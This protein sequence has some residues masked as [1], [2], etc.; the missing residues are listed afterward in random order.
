MAVPEVAGA[1]L[2]LIEFSSRRCQVDANLAVLVGEYRADTG[3][4]PSRAVARWQD[5]PTL[6]W[7][8][9][10]GGCHLNRPIDQLISAPSGWQCGPITSANATCWCPRTSAT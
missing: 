5:L 9:V 3:R 8:R 10:A 2:R 6:L 1:D 7:R 4:A